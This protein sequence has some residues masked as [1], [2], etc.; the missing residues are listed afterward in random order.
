M[1]YN[2]LYVDKVKD[3]QYRPDFSGCTSV[4]YDTYTYYYESIEQEDQVDFLDWVAITFLD[5]LI[6]DE[7][8]TTEDFLA[9]AGV[10]VTFPDE[11]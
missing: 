6:Q 9:S 7:D 1:E 5:D 10:S 4:Y 2:Y 3:G 8:Q 11:F